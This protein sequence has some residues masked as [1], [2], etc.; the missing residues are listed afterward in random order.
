MCGCTAQ[1]QEGECK[2]PQ[3]VLLQGRPKSLA[4]SSRV[5][6][7]CAQWPAF[8]LLLLQRLGAQTATGRHTMASHAACASRASPQATSQVRCESCWQEGSAAG[9]RALGCNGGASGTVGCC[10]TSPP[11]PGSLQK[12]P[13]SFTPEEALP[14]TVQQF[15][16]VLHHTYLACMCPPA[17]PL[18]L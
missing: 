14:S 7:S 12:A 5:H 18:Y 15:T 9:Q 1:K 4:V 2:L 11:G 8:H 6:K 3:E 17:C 10:F 16:Q 13:S